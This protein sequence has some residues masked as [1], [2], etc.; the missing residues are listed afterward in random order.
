MNKMFW[1][2][3]VY[4]K[5]KTIRNRMESEK[6]KISLE[7]FSRPYM[8][9]YSLHKQEIVVI[10]NWIR[11]VRHIL[12]WFDLLVSEY[13]YHNCFYCI[14]YVNVSLYFSKVDVDLFVPWTA[15]RHVRACVLW[16]YLFGGVS[17]RRCWSWGSINVFRLLT[18]HPRRALFVAILPCGL[19]VRSTCEV[20]WLRFNAW[21]VGGS[22][23]QANVTNGVT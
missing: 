14:V 1:F 21:M 3:Y 19:L 12:T 6:M 16:K 2:F 5:G 10:S 7:S 23:L 15:E 4:Q 20:S 9:I 18:R 11:T 13:L 22:R 8:V 17:W